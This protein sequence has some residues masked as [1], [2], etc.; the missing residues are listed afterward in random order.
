M[1]IICEYCRTGHAKESCPNCGGPND[2]Y[3]KTSA[4]FEL[5]LQTIVL[6]NGLGIRSHFG[7]TD[8]R[9]IYK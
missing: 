2:A 3:R 7:W 9:E 6:Q 1:N 8:P 4:D 5:L